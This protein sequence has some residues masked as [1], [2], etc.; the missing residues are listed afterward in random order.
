MYVRLMIRF[1]NKKLIFS[2]SAMIFLLTVA[3]SGVTLSQE[4]Q[5]EKQN[6]LRQASLEWMQVGIRQY[7][8]GQFADAEKSF[9]RA[10]IYKKYLTEAERL[11]INEFLTKARPDLSEEILPAENT[12]PAKEEE[13]LKN[14][15]SLAIKEQQQT[16]KEPKIINSRIEQEDSSVKSSVPDVSE[17][18]LEAGSLG[19][20]I[21]VK[22][23]SFRSELM[24]LSDWLLENRRNVLLIGLPVLA[25]LVLIS[26]LQGMKRRPGR[27]VYAYHVPA[28]S[29]FIG[30]RL[31]AGDE[32]NRRFKGSK[33]KPSGFAASAKPKRKGFE[34][35][36]EHWKEK[37]F[38]HTPVADE[39]SLTSEKWPQ[40]KDKPA[41][42]DT[43]VAEVEKKQCGK[44]K[45]FKPHSDF[46]KNKSTK[47]GL[48]R[49]CKQCKKEYSKKRAA[50]KK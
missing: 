34:Q 26:K 49:W 6:V 8:S 24:R 15:E 19:D 50:E 18:Q 10:L 37:H 20:V 23:K 31:T 45:Q 38:G 47:D 17:N 29:S 32:N 43:A 48:A 3:L 39:K 36:T 44:C 12:Q 9:R 33:N 7:Q 42:A 41:V 22:D 27:R 21:V 5:A 28:S 11:K 16:E 2:L 40:Q 30:A 13:Q 14:S 35:S 4:S 1:R 25:V 46:Y